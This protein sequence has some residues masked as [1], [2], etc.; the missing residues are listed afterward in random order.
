[1]YY[2]LMLRPK[3]HKRKVIIYVAGFVV[4]ALLAFQ[5]VIDISVFRNIIQVRP[6][7]GTVIATLIEDATKQLNKP[8]PV[9]PSTGKV[10]ICT[11]PGSILAITLPKFI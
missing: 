6:E 7:Y 9:D 10:Y 3:L 5:T 4:L 2:L 8:A 11:R 1:M